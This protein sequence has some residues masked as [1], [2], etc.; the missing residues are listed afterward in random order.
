MTPLSQLFASLLKDIPEDP[1]LKSAA[2]RIAWKCCVGEGIRN[3]STPENLLRG[4]LYV[5]VTDPQWKSTLESM[6]PELISRINGYLRKKM[7]RDLRI[8]L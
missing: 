6:K 4:V 8:V 1:E 2:V 7:I 5:K 3:A